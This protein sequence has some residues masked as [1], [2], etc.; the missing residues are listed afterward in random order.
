MMARARTIHDIIERFRLNCRGYLRRYRIFIVLLILSGL[1]DM[2]STIH[3]M[4]VGGAED[5]GHPAIRL[6]SIVLGPV[7][8]PVVGKLGQLAARYKDT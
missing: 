4:L 7:L 5:E 1:A 8:G 2:L 6:I 3:F